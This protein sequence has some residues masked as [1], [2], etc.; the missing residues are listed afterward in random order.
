MADVIDMRLRTAK[1]LSDHFIEHGKR[2]FL[3]GGRK[4]G[5]MLITWDQSGTPDV[6]SYYNDE[7]ITLEQLYDLL[8]VAM[9]KF[10][11]VYCG[12]VEN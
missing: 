12:P 1:E 11:E 10:D 7:E 8:D 9:Q 6:P 5:Y 2:H 4:Y 3:N